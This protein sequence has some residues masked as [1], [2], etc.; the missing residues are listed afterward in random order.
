MVG[1]D[2]TISAAEPGPV[3]MHA[4]WRLE[5][6][7]TAAAAYAPNQ[8]LAALA[9]AGSVGSGLA[10]RY[11]DLELDC[12]W[13]EPPADRDRLDPIERL[14]GQVEA[15]WEFDSDDEEWSEDY[16]LGPLH[17]TISNF[18]VATIERFLDAVTLRADTDPA[19]HMRLAAIQR[20]CP[21]A[22]Q[23]LLAGWRAR[24]DRYPDALV[25][26][27]VRRSLAPDALPGWPARAALASR[28]DEIA[29]HA[30]LVAV[31]QAVLGAM[32]AVNRVYPPHRLAKWQRHLLAGL[33]ITPD[34]LADRLHALSRPDDAAVA[35]DQAE[36]LLAETVRLAETAAG[37]QLAEFRELLAERR[38]AVDPPGSPAGPEPVTG[39]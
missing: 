12:Y 26:A 7:R 16:R 32:L 10:D 4:A 23:E 37:I 38:P 27:M 11:S 33:T 2:V 39:S 28:G 5:A 25:A 17:V 13:H 8:R 15:F 24:A 31:Q 34:H 1:W 14:G 18:T 19:R 35:L 20:C 3:S 6:A 30:L 36:D 22:G 9:A 21:L 29:V